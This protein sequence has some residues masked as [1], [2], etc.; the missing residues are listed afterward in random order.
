[1]QSE[2]PTG[3]P[4]GTIQ[5]N[6]EQGFRPH[7]SDAFLDLYGEDTCFG[8]AQKTAPKPASRRVPAAIA[9]ARFA[10]PNG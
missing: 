5:I 8:A 10:K 1:M 6:P 3:V 4:A 7:L 9:A 2:R